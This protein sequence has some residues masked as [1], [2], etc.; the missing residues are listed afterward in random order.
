MSKTEQET[1]QWVAAE[2]H[3]YLRIYGALKD[4]DKPL[5]VAGILLALDEIE[6]GGF[7]LESMTGDQTPSMRDG[8]KLMHAIQGRLTRS[9]VG[10]DV[11]KDKLLS[12]FSILQ[13]SLRL[14]E[15]S[16][17]LGKTPLKFYTE[18][19]YEHVFRNIKYLKSGED[20]IG[21]FYGEFMSY[22]GGDGQTLGIILTPRHICELMCALVDIQPDDIVLDP[23][24]GTAGFLIAA[25]HRMLSLASSDYQKKQ[26]K[27]RQL[28]GFEIQS[29][30]FVVAAA[31]MILRRDGN[32]NL[33]CCDFLKKNPAQVQLKGATVGLINP[34]YSQGTKTDQGQY[35]LS[36]VE[37]MLDSLLHGARAAAI[38]PQSA[39]T[40]KSL[41]EQELKQRL[42]L[43]HTLEGVITCNKDTFYGV[44]TAPVIAV[45]TA[46]KPHDPSKL[47]K[48]IDF[49]EDGYEVRP[50]V[51]LIEGNSAQDKRQHLLDVWFNRTV[52]PSKF[53]VTSTVKPE[54]EWLFSFYYF[55]DN[56]P[57]ES[58]F[59][60]AIGEY[61][62][63]EFAMVMQNREYLFRG[64]PDGERDN[65]GRPSQ[66]PPQLPF[67]DLIAQCH[68]LPVTG[69]PVTGMPVTGSLV[70]GAELP[71]LHCKEWRAF[72][73]D[74]LFTVTSG[75]RLESRNKQPGRLPFVGATEHDNGVTG[76]VGN[77]NQSQD[78]NVLG[79]NYNGAPC[80]A[81]Y[82]PYTC[83]FSDD[84]KRLHLRH[85]PNN[86]W[87]LLF[88]KVAFAQQRSKYSYGYKCHDKRLLRQK[89]MLPVTTNH[90]PDYA[91]MEQYSK[92]LIY[93]KYQQYLA[94]L[95]LV[96]V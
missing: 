58:A 37:H 44:R 41:I 94:Y 71:A 76:F 20:F 74:E 57:T 35:E 86:P 80:V 56:I 50:H 51:G 16:P 45:F 4:Q 46:H 23:T 53:C 12:E 15:V 43:K 52:A 62:T 65:G 89:L 14:N 68:A 78:C 69:S 73:V 17:I 9:N 10:P 85:H 61:L 11:K 13:N 93:R 81:F 8:D 30:M 1:Y 48:F 54:D 83:L 27:Q 66:Q 31:N 47:C 59:E 64:E 25:M 3:N 40:G 38:V 63:F 42:M 82:H 77:T 34:P 60:Q 88:L 6:F 36:F 2:L 79:V 26:I 49:R 87:V 22:S 92:S 19:L 33:E 72:T 67:A 32:S 70:T 7:S 75:K 24:C 91:Y 96:G 5:V 29:N 90:E 84:V 21:R 39:L 18:F 28:H 55:N 95:G